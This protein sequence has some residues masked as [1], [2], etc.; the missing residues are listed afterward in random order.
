[1]KRLFALL[2]A[3]FSLFPLYWA[4]LTATRKGEALH[5]RSLIPG[6]PDLSNFAHVLGDPSFARDLM[7][8]VLCAALTVTVSLVLGLPAAFATSRRRFRGRGALLTTILLISVFPQIAVLSG[9]FEL[10]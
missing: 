8:S 6:S 9:L 3:L 1:M 7:N 5:S 2:V 4:L 10:L